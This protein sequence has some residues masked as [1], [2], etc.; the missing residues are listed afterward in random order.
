MESN[1]AYRGMNSNL[2]QTMLAHWSR[3]MDLHHRSPGYEPGKITTSLPRNVW[4]SHRESNPDLKLA[5]LAFSRLTM[6]PQECK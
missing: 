1:H 5:K 6:T 2:S 4:W 3:G